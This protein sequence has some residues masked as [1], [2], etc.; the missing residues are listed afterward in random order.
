[1]LA[2]D[3]LQI[4]FM[5]VPYVCVRCSRQ[6]AR[7]KFQR[8]ISDFVSLGR[9]VD[10][11]DD[12]RGT[13]QELPST[14][15]NSP[16]TAL[17]PRKKRLKPPQS[18]QR[19]R[20]PKGDDPNLE[21]LFASNRGQE[22]A[23]EKFRYSRTPKSQPQPI[24]TPE[25]EIS[26]I[27]R[28][29]EFRCL[30]LSNRSRR[31][32]VPLQ[33]IWRDCEILL[34]DTS[35]IRKGT[36]E[37]GDDKMLS[38]S[39]TTLFNK[40]ENS[41]TLRDVLLAICQSQHLVIDGRDLTPADAI[42]TY[43]KHGVMRN[44]WSRVLWC[45][46]GQVLQL[47]DQSTYESVEAASNER[48]R[49]ILGRILEVWEVYEE[50]YGLRSSFFTVPVS[51]DSEGMNDQALTSEGSSS[52]LA[53]Q[54]QLHPHDD[55]TIAAAMTLECL[56]A[57]GVKEP[58]RI[59]GLFNRPG[60]ALK[61]DR[62]IATRCLL[63]AGVSS[64][65]IEKALEGWE[66]RTSPEA[67]KIIKPTENS[68]KP[69]NLGYPLRVSQKRP[70]QDWSSMGLHERLLAI[71]RTSERSNPQLAI[72]LWRRFQA[73]VE[74]NKSET[75]RD[76][77]DHIYV[78]FLRTFW[79]L[80]RHN[81]AI[82]VWNHMFKCG[83]PFKPKHW[84]AM[85]NGCIIAKDVES[86]QSLWTKMQNSGVL[87]DSTT[88][89]TYIHGLIEGRKWEEGLKA[90][91]QLGRIWRSAPP[92]KPSDTTSDNS[93]G[94]NTGNDNQSAEESKFGSILRPT[95]NPVGAALS[96]LIHI[97]KRSLIPRVLAWA[98]SHQVPLSG[99]TFNILLRPIV[100]HGTQADIQAHLQRM[101]EANCTPDVVTFTIILNGL[102]SNPTSAFRTL[103]PEAQENTIVSILADMEAQGIEPTAF[104]YGT[105]LDGLLTPAGSS[106]RD[107]SS[108]SSSSSLDDH[109]PNVQAARTVLAHM[110]ARKIYPST[111]VYTILITHYFTRR[112][113]PD[114]PAVASLW[115]SIRHSNQYNRL[116]NIFF[117]RLI[118]GY[119]D[120]D[121]LDEALKFLQLM[122]RY[123]NTPGWGALVR[124]LTALVR[125]REWG[126]CGELVEDVERGDGSLRVGQGRGQGR[127]R[128]AFWEL[129][130]LL[131]EKGVVRSF[132]EER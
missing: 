87:P 39:L 42:K 30:E 95:E 61:R 65:V 71:G 80:R 113:S 118:E 35:R 73:D 81:E 100:R 16:A 5:N 41:Y 23:V 83:Y 11:D 91:E 90:L 96:A 99:H 92:L 56:E 115:A 69:R 26:A 75:E 129:V 36:G 98:R 67:E 108:S 52:S 93:R 21:A 130:D 111:H 132:D 68:N 12:S 47:K 3:C 112:P 34:G 54:R 110:A 13:L 31:R 15:G 45:Q 49:I 4:P 48:I 94:S 78:R 126:L 55:T 124:L 86:L 76:S 6:F 18:F 89:T 131:K 72:D 14:N 59:I 24:Q 103:P 53:Y 109:T 104:T 44:W 105:L 122:P 8:R 121:E 85:L 28:S 62:S 116:D 77:H 7:L 119:A 123:G 46:L 125:A 63:H 117:D 25:I 43:M 84:T 120:N 19:Q 70:D 88:W 33:E 50:R 66:S 127:E 22:Q 60:Q 29:L 51:R 2:D 27:I 82:E 101:A 32:T 106:S 79:A 17:Q 9:L 20:K 1:M 57:A 128:G 40:P 64:K 37:Y 107:P 58:S 10:R 74:A 114:L 102:V 97:N 38:N